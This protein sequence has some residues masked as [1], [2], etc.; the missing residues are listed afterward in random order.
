MLILCELITFTLRNSIMEKETSFKLSL[1]QAIKSHFN[2]VYTYT[3]NS[4][5]YVNYK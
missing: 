3:L 2:D 5:F 4:I 1:V